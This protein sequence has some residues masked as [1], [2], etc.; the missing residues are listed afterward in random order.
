MF[1]TRLRQ[2]RQERHLSQE[3]LATALHIS[4]ATVAGYET[5]YREPNFQTLMQIAELFHVTADELLHEPIPK[6]KVVPTKQKKE[7]HKSLNFSKEDLRVCR[8]CLQQVCEGEEES[9]TLYQQQLV[10]R[11]DAYLEGGMETTYE[12]QQ[13][14]ITKT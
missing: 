6:Q 7:E 14:E 13:E 8:Y 5:K 10:R 4:R 2:L 12:S 3:E 1:A 9:K 11:I